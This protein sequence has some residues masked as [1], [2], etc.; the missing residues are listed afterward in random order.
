MIKLYCFPR[1]G[2]SREVKIVLAEKGIPYDPIDIHAD[3]SVLESPDFL[4]ASPKKT[5]PAIIDGELAMSEAYRINEYVE[6]K[7]SQNPLLPN[8]EASRAKIRS[9]VAGA[10]KRLCLKVG[11]LLIECL[12]KPKE[13]QKEETKVRLRSEIFSA[14]KEVND[15]LG[16][17]EYFFENYSLADV[18]LTPHLAAL[19][20]VGIELG[21]DVPNI[22]RW[23]ERVKARPSFSAS[24]EWKVPV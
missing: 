13:Q 9:W 8:D 15:F 22:K 10:D 7:Y 5:V 21:E 18:S 3:K 14:L 2:N 11:L 6:D 24:A 4:K 16:P 17:K 1:S 23:F 19:P 20:R 12:L